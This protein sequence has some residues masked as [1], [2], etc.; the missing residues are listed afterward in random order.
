[1]KTAEREILAILRG[2]VSISSAANDQPKWQ[3]RIDML[4]RSLKSD[5][6]AVAVEAASKCYAHGLRVKSGLKAKFFDKDGEAPDDLSLME[7][8]VIYG[9]APSRFRG[10]HAVALRHIKPAMVLSMRL[11]VDYLAKLKRMVEATD[12][13]ESHEAF[14]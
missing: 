3:R 14:S 13:K 1:M 11:A 2:E 12:A 10:P 6:Y 7:R 8:L 5:C 9:L 4:P